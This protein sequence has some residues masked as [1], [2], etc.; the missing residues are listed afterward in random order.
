RVVHT[1]AGGASAGGVVVVSAKSSDRDVVR[2]LNLGACDYVTKPFDP[3]DLVH[4]V[5]WVLASTP[6][7]LDAHRQETI[8]RCG[9]TAGAESPSEPPSA[10]WSSAP[11]AGS[12]RCTAVM[13]A[14]SPPRHS[15]ASASAQCA[16]PPTSPPPTPGAR[17]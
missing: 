7:E 1:R 11:R 5:E 14:R 8:E 15:R 3:D 2:A 17:P 4:V 12:R 10:F 6:E 16:S 9:G 13:P